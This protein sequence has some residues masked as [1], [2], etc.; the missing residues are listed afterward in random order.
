MKPISEKS[1]ITIGLLIAI[2][3][4]V[5][6]I[7]SIDYRLQ[8]VEVRMAEM[9]TDVKTILRKSAEVAA[10]PR[11]NPG[12]YSTTERPVHREERKYGLVD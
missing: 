7:S 5:W 6:K 11:L 9:G 12:P 8:N 4:A 1:P 10:C 3:G 2:C